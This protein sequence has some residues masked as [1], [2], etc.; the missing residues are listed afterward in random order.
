MLVGDAPLAGIAFLVF[1]AMAWYKQPESDTIMAW[2][3]TL[4]VIAVI[5]SWLFGGGVPEPPGS[6]G[7]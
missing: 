2:I 1:A 6:F 4:A 5:H 3:F 7:Y